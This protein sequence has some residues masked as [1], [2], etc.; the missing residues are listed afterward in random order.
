MRKFVVDASVAAKWMLPAKGELLRPEAYRLLDSYGAGEVGLLVPDIFW[1]ECGNIAWK[2]VRQQ[3]FS[4]AEAELAILLMT[5]RAIPT[6]PS[7]ELLSKAL[8]IAFNFG[9]SVYDSLYVALAVQAE[10]QL[11]TAD[12]SL[13]NALAAH[14]PVKWLGAL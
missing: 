6:I 2:A 7:A 14:L 5:Q 12:E 10:R 3:R 11:I 8:T 4:R 1:A 9:R 13:A